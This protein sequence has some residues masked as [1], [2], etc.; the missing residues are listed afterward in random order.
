MSACANVRLRRRCARRSR[1]PPRSPAP[2]GRA[3][4]TGAQPSFAAAIASVPTPQPKSAAPPAG[5]MSSSS[6]E[7]HL[8]RRVR[9]RAE[10]AAAALDHDLHHAARAPAG[11]TA[12]GPRAGPR[13]APRRRRSGA[14]ARAS[15]P[16]R[17][18]T[19]ASSSA[20]GEAARSASRAR[21]RRAE[22][23][24]LRRRP[25]P[26]GR[27]T[28]PAGSS[29]STPSSTSSRA[30][31]GMRKETRCTPREAT[32]GS[33]LPERRGVQLAPQLADL[34]A[35][36]GGVLEAQ[37]LGRGEHLLLE[38]DDRRLDLGRR[39][40]DL[41]LA[42]AAALGRDL[43]VRHQ[44]LRDVGDALDDRL[45]RDAVLLVVGA[46][47]SRAGGRSRAI[48][49]RIASVSLSAYITTL[50]SMLRAARPIVW[51]SDVAPRRKPSLS[52]SRIADQRDLRAGPG[53]RAGG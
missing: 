24:Q 46:A 41:L 7:A 8:R 37:L 18:R 43:G 3:R 11:R 2:R 23:R 51:I 38:L 13:S 30:A 22:R 39:H 27:S 40:V 4:T 15:R 25:S 20:T 9:A 49:V 50:P 19:R 31:S 1:A 36:L 12:S 28:I 42:P 34:V 29:G 5:S 44:E 32:A 10:P 48:A 33:R 47:G 16:A 21:Q 17:P 52:A 14:A 35:Q 26:T 53:P 45:R 6:A